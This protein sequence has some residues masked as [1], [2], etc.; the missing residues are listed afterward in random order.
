MQENKAESF[1]P[2]HQQDC[3]VADVADIYAAFV[4]VVLDKG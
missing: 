4:S 2:T 3:V 1:S